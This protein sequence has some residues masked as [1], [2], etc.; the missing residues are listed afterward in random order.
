S[1]LILLI[2]H[3]AIGYLRYRAG[4]D[5]LLG[6]NRMFDLLREANVPTWYSSS[7]LLACSVLL[8]SIA[9]AAQS[10][11][12]GLVWHWYGLAMLLA[13]MSMDEAALIHETV[14]RQLRAGYQPEDAFYSVATILFPA[15]LVL[16]VGIAYL[17]FLT[18][19]P[20]RT[21]MLFLAAAAIF[22]SG[23][24]LMDFV[25]ELHKNERGEANMTYAM[26]TGFEEALEMVGVLV[27]LYGLLDYLESQ[28]GPV[29][30]AVEA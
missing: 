11:S 17:R 27:F 14:Q 24:L 21:M 22:V 25:G 23:A 1:V 12:A 10:K 8:V 2:A 4:H 28:I 29:T 5:H 19:L 26:L 13:Y 9:R 6:L 16:A 20:R 15:F 30:F 7:T 18:R 3:F